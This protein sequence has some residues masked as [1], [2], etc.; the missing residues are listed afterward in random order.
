MPKLLSDL[1]TLSNIY[2]FRLHFDIRSITNIHILHTDA[3]IYTSLHFRGHP[4]TDVSSEVQ[5]ILHDL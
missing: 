3:H 5:M 1:C 4:H 2:M